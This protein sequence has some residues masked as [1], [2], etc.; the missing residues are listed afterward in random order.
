MESPNFISFTAAKRSE[1]IIPAS[2]LVIFL[3]TY[4]VNSKIS[5]FFYSNF[6]IIS[7]AF[8][9]GIFI[10]E[11]STV[12]I[13]PLSLFPP[14]PDTTGADKELKL[15]LFTILY[16]NHDCNQRNTLL[17]SHH[18]ERFGHILNKKFLLNSLLSFMVQVIENCNQ[19]FVTNIDFWQN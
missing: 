8:R 1:T 4:F 17:L 11:V 3:S 14:P 10:W 15:Q 16:A 9:L 2:K 12:L 19:F 18:P 6:F 13:S 7:D 5:N